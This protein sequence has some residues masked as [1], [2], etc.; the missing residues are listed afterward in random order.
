ML[1]DSAVLATCPSKRHTSASRHSVRTV[2]ASHLQRHVLLPIP[3]D[4]TNTWVEP[5]SRWR[6]LDLQLFART[7]RASAISAAIEGGAVSPIRACITCTTRPEYS[8]N[9]PLSSRNA[10]IRD[11]HPEAGRD[12][13]ERAARTLS[14][15]L[16]AGPLASARSSSSASISQTPNERLRAK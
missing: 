8:G 16:R 14:P 11:S 4:P 2:R 15:E 5:C 10:L 13:E 6:G 1:S 7:S 12:G 9:R 3:G